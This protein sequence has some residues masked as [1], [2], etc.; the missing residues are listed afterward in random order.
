MSDTALGWA[1]QHSVGHVTRVRNLDRP[2]NPCSELVS[3]ADQPAVTAIVVV[4]SLKV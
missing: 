1:E 3:K 4:H 2:R